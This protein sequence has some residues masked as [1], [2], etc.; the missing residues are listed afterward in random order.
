MQPSKCKDDSIKAKQRFA[1]LIL[2]VVFFC[3]VLQIKEARGPYYYGFNDDP[4]YAYLLNA[5]NLTQGFPPHQVDH[6]GT[7][8]QLWSALA[9]KATYTLK[10]GETHS[11]LEKSVLHLPEHY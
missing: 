7:P 2:P 3:I 11:T 10:T 9:T 4:E 6:P 5:L 8:L 1:L